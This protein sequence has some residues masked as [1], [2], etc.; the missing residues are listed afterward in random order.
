MACTAIVRD[1]KVLAWCLRHPGCRHIS[2]P[3]PEPLLILLAFAEPLQPELDSSSG[4]VLFCL[5]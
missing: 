2:D 1:T 5:I 4:A 3:F